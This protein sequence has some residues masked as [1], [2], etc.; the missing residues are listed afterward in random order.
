MNFIII[1]TNEQFPFLGNLFEIDNYFDWKGA[2]FSLMLLL[3][4]F[5]KSGWFY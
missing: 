2:I 4:N 1:L 5:L 3:L